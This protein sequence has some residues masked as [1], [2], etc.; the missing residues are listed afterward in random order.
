VIKVTVER[1]NGEKEELH[2]NNL[3]LLGK[4]AEQ[5]DVVTEYGLNVSVS[6]IA[7]MLLSGRV[8][9]RAVMLANSMK[10]IKEDMTADAE[11]N[12]LEAIMGG[13]EN[14]TDS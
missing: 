2:L 9:S 3:I 5:D 1:D 6:M 14:G 12:L 13:I 11:D 8:T 7:A 10:K 4:D